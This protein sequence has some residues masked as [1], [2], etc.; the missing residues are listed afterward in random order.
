MKIKP[1]HY[2]HLQNEFKKIDP[3]RIAAH[4]E[5]LQTDPRV[6]DLEKRLRWDCLWSVG[7]S[8]YLSDNIYS[9]AND[10]HIDTAL[11]KIMKELNFESLNV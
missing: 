4:R 5:S 3:A 11:K 6:K 8:R 2:N 7:L 9:Y 10:D 1:E